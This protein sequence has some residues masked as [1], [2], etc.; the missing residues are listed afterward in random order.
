MPYAFHYTTLLEVQNITDQIPEYPYPVMEAATALLADYHAGNKVSLLM[1]S[2][3]AFGGRLKK[4]S[5]V[6]MSILGFIRSEADMPGS[7][8]PVA[9]GRRIPVIGGRANGPE[10]GGGTHIL[11]LTNDRSPAHPKAPLEVNLTLTGLPPEFS[12][13]LL[14]DGVLDV[15]VVEHTRSMF[16]RRRGY[17]DPVTKKPKGFLEVRTWGEAA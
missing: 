11:A 12:A 9:S 13:A 10:M 14:K 8:I 3:P 6:L 1:P 4:G 5:V 16:A 7:R 2:Y 17:K 15:Q